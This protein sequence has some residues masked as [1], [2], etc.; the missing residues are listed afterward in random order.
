MSTI[1]TSS[2]YVTGGD[3]G[4]DAPSYV[5]RSADRELYEALV[6]G[7]YCYILN[8]RQ[9]GKSSLKVRAATRLRSEGI[10]VA[11]LDLAAIGTNLTPEQWYGGLLY[12]LGEDLDLEPELSTFWRTHTEVAPL[13]RWMR[14]LHEVVLTHCQGPVVI[15][16]D[17]IDTA[18]CLP[19]STDEF[20]AALRECYTRR[21]V[22]PEQVRLVFCLL[23]VATPHDLIRDPRMTPFNV[24]RRIELHDFSAQ[25]AEPLAQG[26][27]RGEETSKR[28]LERVLYWTGGHP[29]LTQSLCEAVARDPDVSDHRGVDRLCAQKFFTGRA[30]E[31]DK[32]LGTIR[33]YLLRE[34]VPRAEI[35]DLYSQ[36]RRARGLHAIPTNPLTEIVRLSGIARAEGNLLRVR[37]RIYR[38]VF[39]RKWV[40][41]SMPNADWKRRRKAFLKGFATAM[42]ISLLALFALLCILLYQSNQNREWAEANELAAEGVL[43]STTGVIRDFQSEKVLQSSPRFQPFKPLVRPFYNTMARDLLRD[44][45]AKYDPLPESEKETTLFNRVVAG[46]H[47]SIG[48]LSLSSQDYPD[49][50]ENY[51]KAIKYQRHACDLVREHMGI[52]NRRQWSNHILKQYESELNA[53]YLHLIILLIKMDRVPEAKS[54]FVHR[55]GELLGDRAGLSDFARLLAAGASP[56][57]RGKN[58]SE[59]QRQDLALLA[60]RARGTLADQGR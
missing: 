26:L 24:G 32:N 31:V 14:A 51:D 45:V 34:D 9:L 22:D 57:E 28:L 49:A 3:L 59:P 37:N 1:G 16:I 4:P 60:E 23:G 35:L 47:N 40:E 36:T 29:Y 7:E 10:A 48:D 56:K 2:F 50:K 33:S 54:V 17:E 20:F 5:L 43:V 18:L 42:A 19:F 41:A 52:I 39:D 25:E 8:S 11:Q 53:Y 55:Q 15:F 27:G 21:A 6:Q 38:R 30:R 46:T 12:H 58:L 13:L 44:M